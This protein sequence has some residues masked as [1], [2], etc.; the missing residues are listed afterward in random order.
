ME[1]MKKTRTLL[2]ITIF[3]IALITVILIFCNNDF[4]YNRADK[5]LWGE[6]KSTFIESEIERIELISDEKIVLGNKEKNEF[7]KALKVSQFYRS[8]WRKEGPT[9]LMIIW[10]L[11]KDGSEKSFSYWGN[12]VLETAYKDRQFLIKNYELEKFMNRNSSDINN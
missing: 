11:Y 4:R 1:R 6:L 8:N 12:G 5:I 7:I 2:N 10:I 9:G 3:S